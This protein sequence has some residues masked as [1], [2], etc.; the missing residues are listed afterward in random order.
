[1]KKL[2]YRIKPP[3]AKCPYILGLVQFIENP[4]LSC[5][6]NGY[7]MYDI[8]AHGKYKHDEV[9]KDTVIRHKRL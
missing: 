3:C 6:L 8:L 1:M 7:S 5:K 2:L 4:C 9:K